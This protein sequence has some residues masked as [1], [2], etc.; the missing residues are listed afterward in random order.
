MAS[1]IDLTYD[2]SSDENAVSESS[3]FQNSKTRMTRQPLNQIQNNVQL[4][5]IASVVS[6]IDL[7]PALTQA[8]RKSSEKR[9]RKLLMRVCREHPAARALVEREFLVPKSEVVPY[10]A[11]TESEDGGANS[12]EDSD[13]EAIISKKKS[14]NDH[15]ILPTPNLKR[16]AGS[17][18]EELVPRFAKCENCKEE[19]DVTA[20]ER[21][22]CIWHWGKASIQSRVVRSLICG[23]REEGILRR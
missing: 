1:F 23:Y 22:D 16:K 21:G 13:D 20:N 9:V 3:K 18:D 2:G 10:H 11:D 15:A 8:L 6:N 19:F 7:S 12:E 14:E 4:P 5:P 17:I